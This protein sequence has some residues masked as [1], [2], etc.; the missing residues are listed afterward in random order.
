M[1]YYNLQ[2]AHHL[3]ESFSQAQQD[4]LKPFLP[5]LPEQKTLSEIIEDVYEA[6]MDEPEP[7]NSDRLDEIH[8][9][10]RNLADELSA[11][12][13][14]LYLEDYEELPEGSVVLAKGQGLPWIKRGHFWH[15]ATMEVR[16]NKDMSGVPR[17]I[18]REGQGDV[19]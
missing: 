9:Q 11:R 18:I 17:K 15:S 13:S 10:L 5:E 14:V 19:C 7:E 2:R 4:V 16:S 1:K 8:F 3:V 6:Y 12:E